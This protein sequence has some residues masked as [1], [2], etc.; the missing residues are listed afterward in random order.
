[1]RAAPRARGTFLPLSERYFNVTFDTLSI[2]RT[3]P[4]LRH[5][6]ICQIFRAIVFHRGCSPPGGPSE[7]F[8]NRDSD[9]TVT[10]SSDLCF[11]I[12]SRQIPSPIV[13]HTDSLRSRNLSNAYATFHA[14]IDG[15]RWILD[16][17]R[18]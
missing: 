17:S 1:M 8:A 14:A 12:N 2:T 5:A 11:A 6:R 15:F 16:R 13:F 10:S 4:A 7:D 3:F 18:S 9:I